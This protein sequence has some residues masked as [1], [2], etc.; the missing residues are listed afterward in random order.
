[1]ARGEDSHVPHIALAGPKANCYG[2]EI[3]RVTRAAVP[4]AGC[5][6]VLQQFCPLPKLLILFRNIVFVF[7]II[8]IFGNLFTKLASLMATVFCTHFCRFLR[9][10]GCFPHVFHG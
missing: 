5:I 7:I 4:I 6:R 10:F 3:H 2:R 8:V 1:M 9:L